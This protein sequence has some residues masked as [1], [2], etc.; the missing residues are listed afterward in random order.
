M[1]GQAQLFSRDCPDS[2]RI[3]EGKRE[4]KTTERDYSIIFLFVTTQEPKNSAPGLTFQS[5]FQA[6]GHD[7][8]N[9]AAAWN[10]TASMPLALRIPYPCT[11]QSFTV[12]YALAAARHRK[13][14]Q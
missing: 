5:N 8:D 2:D 12:E 1:T 11:P 3:C 4:V 7:D 13:A 14:R 10:K 9:R 6:G